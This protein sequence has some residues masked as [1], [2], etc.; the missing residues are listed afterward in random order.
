MDVLF[1]FVYDSKERK[2][3]RQKGMRVERGVSLSVCLSQCNIH[4]IPSLG[5]VVK[6][7]VLRQL[8]SLYAAEYV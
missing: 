6:D 8:H 2:S 3:R 5:K 7:L 1:Y 4:V